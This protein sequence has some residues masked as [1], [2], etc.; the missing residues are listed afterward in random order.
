M[1]QIAWAVLIQK[2]ELQELEAGTTCRLKP[3]T[4]QD[5][6]SCRSRSTD[7]KRFSADH[8]GWHLPVQLI[9]E[10]CTGL[11]RPTMGDTGDVGPG[12]PESGHE[13]CG[14]PDKFMSCKD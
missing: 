8:R 10:A 3:S 4:I 14:Q 12:D 13:C 9:P 6:T 11:L 7:D 5:L 1:E 2:L